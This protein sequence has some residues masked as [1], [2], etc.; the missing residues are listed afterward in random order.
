MRTA[1]SPNPFL[2]PP[3]KFFQQP[4]GPGRSKPRESTL[5]DPPPA[6]GASRSEIT[7]D[8][9]PDELPPPSS[10]EPVPQSE[11]SISLVI[12]VSGDAPPSASSVQL[13][14]ERIP[15]PISALP[16]SPRM[17]PPPPRSVRDAP[18]VAIP[19]GM[20]PPPPRAT[21]LP[22]A[23]PVVREEPFDTELEARLLERQDWPRL[24]ELYSSSAMRGDSERVRHLLQAASLLEIRLGEF[25]RAFFTYLEVLVFAPESPDA[26][27]GIERAA[28]E[29]GVHAKAKWA[30]ATRRL[31]KVSDQAGDPVQRGEYLAL[32]FRWNNQ[33]LRR[34][35]IAAEVFSRLAEI[36]PRHPTVLERRANEARARGDAQQQRQLLL[37]ALPLVSRA[38]DRI[39]VHLALAELLEGPLA[40]RAQALPHYEAVLQESP[41]HFDALRGLERALREAGDPARLRDVLERMVAAAATAKD[42]LEPLIRL[43]ET[44]E[45]E[46]VDPD[47]AASALEEALLIDPQ[48]GKALAALERC[49][50]ALGHWSEVARVM[51]RR[52]AILTAPRAKM[53]LLFSAGDVLEKRA[54]DM[55]GALDAYRMVL[56]VDAK[57]R[58]ALGEL[59]RLAETLSLLDE[60]ISFGTKL[61]EVTPDKR[62]AA[63]IFAELGQE[64]ES[65]GESQLARSN[66]ERALDLDKRNRHVLGALERLARSTGGDERARY[67]LEQRAKLAEDKLEAAELYA[68][69]GRE[70]REATDFGAALEAYAA[71]LSADPTHEEA[72]AA[73]LDYNVEQGNFRAVEPLIELLV[74]GARRDED[75]PRTLHL[76][77]LATRT[78]ASLGKMEQA[79][80]AA[81]AAFDEAPHDAGARSDL[82]EVAT[83]TSPDKIGIARDHLARVAEATDGISTGGLVR[84]A[85]AQYAAGDSRHAITTLEQAHD[86]SPTDPGPLE[87]L[88][89]IFE[90]EQMWERLAVT[91]IE[92]ARMLPLAEEELHFKLLADAGDLWARRLNDVR[93]ASEAFEE[94]R[95]LRPD[96]GWLLETLAWAYR[97]VEEWHKLA[98]VIE[99]LIGSAEEPDKERELLLELAQ[100]QSSELGD[101]SAAA[102]ALE[103]VLDSDASYLKAFEDLVR[104]LTDNRDWNGLEKSYRKM[105]LRVKGQNLVQLELALWRQLG[106]VFRDRLGNNK[107][108]LEAFQ[109]AL[110]RSPEDEELHRIVVELNLILGDLDGAIEQARKRVQH[111]PFEPSTYQTLYDLFLRRGSY[112]LAWCALDVMAQLVTLEGEE[113]ELYAGYPPFPLDE[114]PGTLTE[115]AW[116]THLLD[117]DMDPTLTSLFAWATPAEVRLLERSSNYI[118]HQPFEQSMSDAGTSLTAIIENG[119]EILG[120]VNPPLYHA[121]NAAMPLRPAAAPPGAFLVDHERA[122]EEMETLAF[123]VGRGLSWL[124]SELMPLAFFTDAGELASFLA[125]LVRQD[126]DVYFAM[127]E[128]ERGTVSIIIDQAT[129]DGAKFDVKKWLILAHASSV[130]A[131]VLLSGSVHDAAVFYSRAEDDEHASEKLTAIYQFAVSEEHTDLRTAIG[132]AISQ[133]T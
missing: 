24:V 66:Y 111:A 108:A 54:Y 78:A 25:E 37:E 120:M 47:A 75:A 46:L 98:E 70:R 67:F 19:T 124:R 92:R 85:E 40:A 130:R 63:R 31:K 8:I 90:A 4:T 39:R 121:D 18:P 71:A 60:A 10:D 114:I 27:I 14:L 49:R 72:A 73:M 53:D 82:L 76:L 96:D 7:Y 102:Q 107:N 32:L 3:S 15:S 100:L 21:N 127:T 58:R 88:E 105:L 55:E 59:R 50:E 77:R 57:N 97:E 16:P 101:P 9:D 99:T 118:G 20:P 12:D 43:A 103:R 126:P 129:S 1:A 93:A 38:D 81:M 30:E 122:L 41:D 29:L 68:Q 110:A 74:N 125:R 22:K 112:D 65:R 6:V 115:E 2:P 109:A 42:R 26:A 117:R 5:A 113:E 84:L 61:A 80:L 44:L 94:A 17:P 48:N 34:R 64:L 33:E 119:A 83:R 86:Q 79:L 35:D 89:S 133:T 131:A 62:E 123:H 13:G 28:H 11:S 45:K 36:A 106:L 128:D 69:L 95:V 23:M 51:Q 87:A 56:T 116:Q 104:M 132:T 91:K 52:A